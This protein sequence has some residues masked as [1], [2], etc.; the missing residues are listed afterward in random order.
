MPKSYSFYS[1]FSVERDGTF[2]FNFEYPSCI[3]E[4]VSSSSLSSLN[5]QAVKFASDFFES[6]PDLFEYGY[7]LNLTFFHLNDKS[8]VD[9]FIRFRFQISRAVNEKLP[10]CFEVT[11]SGSTP[12]SFLEIG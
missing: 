8:S 11:P 10:I 4:S 5:R 3:P 2:D 6:N 1:A 9:F 7:I 12:S